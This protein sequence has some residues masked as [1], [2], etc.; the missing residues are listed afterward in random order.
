MTAGVEAVEG[1][2]ACKGAGAGDGFACEP[3]MERAVGCAGEFEA[4]LQE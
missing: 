2:A 1:E 3:E 4:A